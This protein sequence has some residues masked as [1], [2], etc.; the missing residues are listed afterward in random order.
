MRTVAESGRT[1]GRLGNIGPLQATPSEGQGLLEDGHRRR[2]RRGSR[3]L[4]GTTGRMEQRADHAGLHRGKRTARP[5]GHSERACYA[6]RDIRSIDEADELSGRT[7]VR[8]GLVTGHAIGGAAQLALRY[9]II[10]ATTAEPY[11][12]TED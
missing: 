6:V 5:R 2:H 1:T 9:S 11:Q 3:T 10:P 4:L 7:T 8:L 12:S